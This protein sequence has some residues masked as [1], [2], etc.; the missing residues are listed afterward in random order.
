MS[1]FTV[2]TW[3]KWYG[4]NVWQRIFDFGSGTGSY[5]FLT[6]DSGTNTCRFAFK[7]PASGSKEQIVECPMLPTGVWKHVAVSKQGRTV[8]LYIDGVQ[9]AQNTGISSAAS[10]LGVS[11]QNWIGRSQYGSDPYLDGLV[12]DFRIYNRAMS[13]SELAALGSGGTPAS[14]LRFSPPV[15]SATARTLSVGSAVFDNVRVSTTPQVS[16]G[17]IPVPWRVD[18]I[19]ATSAAYA[20][21]DATGGTFLLTGSGGVSTSGSDSVTFLHES[22]YGDGEFVVR[23]VDLPNAGG[24]AQAG[25]SLRETTNP[26]AAC[27]NVYVNASGEAVFSVRST[28]NAATSAIAAID[29]ATPTWLKLRRSGTLLSGYVSSDGVNWTLIGSAS[30]TLQSQM[31]MG[32]ESASTLAKPSTTVIFDHLSITGQDDA[33]GNGLPD[34]WEAFYNVPPGTSGSA[35]APRGDGLTYLQAYQQNLNPNDYYN[36]ITPG[37]NKLDG[38]NQVALTG[39]FLSRPLKIAVTGTSGLPLTNAP[40]TFSVSLGGGGL[41]PSL[42]GSSVATLKVLTD[43]SGYA[44][45]YFRCPAS[46]TNTTC[47]ITFNAG[48]APQLVFTEFAVVPGLTMYYLDPLIGNDSYSGF[49]SGIV[50]GPDGPKLTLSG[51]INAAYSGDT[52]QVAAG[53]YSET[54]LHLGSKTVHLAPNGVVHIH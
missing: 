10:D 44:T 19:G 39:N 34:W 32:L 33:N 13:S 3:V 5:M 38:D 42:T 54:A 37:V 35:L 49:Y 26:G 7:T 30:Q 53:T 29:I 6:P 43:A 8:S 52:I 17:G 40:V 11:T 12:S 16:F 1:D 24:Y 45:V 27:A 47:Q 14:T 46:T 50:T 48:A 22:W 36:G 41:S 51:A 28:T 23:V 18:N 20:A 15:Y 9:V 25:L 21:Y 2:A 4:G 31:E